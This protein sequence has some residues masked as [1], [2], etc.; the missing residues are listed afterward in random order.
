M[1][2]VHFTMVNFGYLGYNLVTFDPVDFMSCQVPA[3]SISWTPFLSR[4]DCDLKHQSLPV[5]K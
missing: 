5:F 2:T 4:P 1:A 3:S